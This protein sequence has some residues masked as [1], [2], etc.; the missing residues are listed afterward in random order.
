M[1][2]IN[3]KEVMFTIFTCLSTALFFF[4]L[5]DCP[6]FDISA[7]ADYQNVIRLPTTPIHLSIC[8]ALLRSVPGS[9]ILAIWGCF[10]FFFFFFFGNV[11][12]CLC[13]AFLFLPTVLPLL[14]IIVL[15]ES[16]YFL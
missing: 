9:T 1:Y 5:M 4:Y 11:Q 15:H 8:L 13:G 12:F 3:V 14:F 16:P 2:A 7:S 10:F 6:S